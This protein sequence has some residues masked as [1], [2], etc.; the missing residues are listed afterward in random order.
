[1]QRAEPGRAVAGERFHVNVAEARGPGAAHHVF[2]RLMKPGRGGNAVQLRQ[3]AD[4]ILGRDA[5]Q[6]LV[7][8][9]QDGAIEQRF[10]GKAR[11]RLRAE[12]R[13]EDNDETGS[14]AHF[15]SLN[16]DRQ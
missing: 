3:T 1:M 7:E 15:R 4:V 14:Q 11:R 13:G 9:R 6:L 10:G 8:R 16:R 2:D 5:G 12:Y